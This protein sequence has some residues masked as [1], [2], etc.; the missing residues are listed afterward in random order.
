MITKR[1]VI[2]SV[3]VIAL[4]FIASAVNWMV[5]TE[6]GNRFIIETTL[7]IIP[8]KIEIKRTNGILVDKL[9][10][11]DISIKFPE[12]EI[13][14]KR[15]DVSLKPSYLTAGIIVFKKVVFNDVSINSLNPGETVNIEW[16]SV[17][18]WLSWLNGRIDELSI[19]R[20]M[21]YS[22]N[23]K[24]FE[25]DDFR[26]AIIWRLGVLGA[27]NATIKM[28]DVNLNGSAWAGFV[29]PS[30]T[31]NIGVVMQEKF[32]N[33]DRI[34]VDMQLMKS[35]KPEHVSG[36]V[37][38]RAMSDKNEP[39]ALKG[40]I[41]L[42]NNDIR[43]KKMV[44]TEKGR[45][46]EALIDG[47]MD[48]AS[49]NI[50]FDLKLKLAGVDLKN[51]LNLK[52]SFSGAI[53]VV[54]NPGHYSGNVYL[55]NEG[56]GWKNI[57]LKGAFDGDM[58]R[59]QINRVNGEF[60]DGTLDGAVR[61]SWVDG[62]SLA[63]DVKGRHMNPSRVV[64]GWKGKINTDAKGLF[65]W[66]K[67]NVLDGEIR[68][69]FLK[70]TLR[71][72][73]LSGLLN[74]GW[75]GGVLQ[76]S[77]FNVR[78]DGFDLSANGFIDERLNYIARISDL[79]GLLP[80]SK[81]RVSMNGWMRL[82][83]RKLVCISKG[84]AS[85]LSYGNLRV[86]A[87][88]IDAGIDEGRDSIYAKIDAYNLGYGVYRFSSLAMTIN[89][90]PIQHNI[91][92][93]LHSK[94][95]NVQAL[96][97]GSYKNA[98]WSG[99]I[100]QFSVFDKNHD[101][102]SIVKPTFL[103]I[104]S[105]Y[106][107][108]GV[109]TMIGKNAERL[110][111]GAKL[112]LVKMKG[113]AK[114]K[115][116]DMNIAR[117]NPFLSETKFFGNSSGS[118]ENEWFSE[119]T[120]RTTGTA[121]MS[122]GFVK[123]PVKVLIARSSASV[124][125]DEKG[126][127][128]SGNVDFEGGGNILLQFLSKQPA[129]AK[130]P[131]YGE[132]KCSWHEVDTS[133]MKPFLPDN[134]ESKGK[135]SGKI[136]GRLT[137]GTQFDISGQT[138]M[139]D[140]RFVWKRDEG[141]IS[142]NTEKANL[143]FTWRESFLMGD[144]DLVL[145]SYGQ[146]KGYFKLPISA[147]LPLNLEKDGHIVLES[148]GKM[149]EKGMVSAIF[150]GLVEETGGQVDFHIGASGTWHRP[151]YK[152]WLTLDKAGAFFP[153]AGVHIKDMNM[154]AVLNNDKIQ[155]D[156]FNAASGK[157]N[158]KGSATLWLKDWKVDR[159]EGKMVGKKFQ[160][161]YVPEI[162][163]QVNPDIEFA[164]NA[165]VFSIHGSVEIPEAIINQGE[166]KKGA[167]RITPDVNIVDAPVKDKK[168]IQGLTFDARI[169]VLLGEN[170]LIKAPGVDARLEGKVLLTGKSVEKI[171]GEGQIKIVRGQY[172]GYGTKLDV[173]RGNIVFSGKPVELATLDIMAL[174][175]IN[176]GRFNEVKAG[177]IITGTPQSPLINLYSEPSMSEADVLS[178]IVLG[179]PIRAEGETSQSALLLRSASAFLSGGKTGSLQTRLMQKI[180]IDTLDVETKNASGFGTGTL[181][182]SP[183]TGATGKS[184][185]TASKTTQG[186]ATIERSLVTI[187]KYIAPGL[188]VAY[189]RS[190]F[191]EE[192]LLTTR[193]SFTKKV[194]I[195]SK[196][197][198]ETSVDLYY[199]IEFD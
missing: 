143:S 185:G 105:G 195:E 103:E 52:T 198:I 170:V 144:L 131:D 148:H 106:F 149:R 80:G 35:G 141:R 194:E 123:G 93:L 121:S 142:F 89:G 163:I 150:P 3:A 43:F 115:W 126:L 90:K 137:P 130:I 31:A 157:G 154:K 178:Y 2:L 51:E 175:S 7:K 102:L 104:G 95:G 186:G 76:I 70:S 118:L 33:I 19:D 24:F 180:G 162:Q 29:R 138:S 79:S 48:F 53:D 165:K 91:Q 193:Y 57:H 125:W 36:A 37:T 129:H 182:T 56:E 14:V 55:Q 147:R 22:K 110:E 169:M 112:D 45:K 64:A 8:A 114:L 168:R 191:T 88:N 113:Y 156:S 97:S 108:I 117:I 145:P 96:L 166:S 84:N 11:E 60:L 44:L 34:L 74:A 9:V 136:S 190:L 153:A 197:G 32:L 176:P 78:G 13:N 6:R 68:A 86:D 15:M 20:L 26:G 172:S 39:F 67:K 133:V 94:E 122:G 81:G 50:V 85:M 30:L 63:A 183:K 124:K 77:A 65:K 174:R 28:P 1:W 179:R 177:V 196:T 46:G 188:Y 5:G 40:D 152:G 83:D 12:W 155:I 38:A 134:L 27:K 41:A 151:E 167:I 116:H 187:G 140:G 119:N 159:Y 128:S 10:M 127:V 181:G 135:I 100:S 184:Y 171:N 47:R 61:M 4:I 25:A 161:V 42:T 66:T 87:A 192:Y 16:P 54:G 146:M 18:V 17:P 158:I 72:K 82:K 92:M 21:V 160:A 101:T 164:G 199:K 69:E 189:G 62:F 139:T 71:N 107:S 73:A 111:A 59:I 49:E 132:I 75:S 120:I 109:L 23:K 98:A 173:T 58:Q 99:H